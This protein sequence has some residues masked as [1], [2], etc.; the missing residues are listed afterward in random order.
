MC[1]KTQEEV[2]NHME[3][4]INQTSVQILASDAGDPKTLRV[5]AE[6]TKLS[7]PFTR[8]YVSFQH[9]HYNAAKSGLPVAYTTY[10]WDNIGF[11]G[12]TYATP[13]A[14]DVPDSLTPLPANGFPGG[15]SVGYHLTKDRCPRK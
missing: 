1:F 9:T 8:G 10:H 15:V 7:L 6:V 12:P 4:H 11:D 14:Y 3:I 2:M 13:R 5:V